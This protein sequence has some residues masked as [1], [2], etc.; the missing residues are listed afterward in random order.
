[1]HEHIHAELT[2][3]LCHAYKQV[4]V[5]NPFTKGTLMGPLIDRQAFEQMQQALALSKIAGF[6]VDG[7]G[8]HRHSGAPNKVI[9]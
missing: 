9:T 8:A 1:M 3:R 6:R 7:G 2:A 4:P 5:G